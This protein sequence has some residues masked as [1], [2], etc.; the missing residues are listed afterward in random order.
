[1]AL[2]IE[3][4]DAPSKTFNHWLLWNLSPQTQEIKE[5]SVPKDAVLG[6][7]DFGKLIY[8]G[9]CPPSGTHRYVF[10]I[11]ALDNK[12][13]LAQNANRAELDEAMKNHILDIGELAG[14]YSKQ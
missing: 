2:I 13:D 3:D 11:Y 4:P 12:L 10:R 1:M 6:T 9:P 8:G 7:N 5:N 14:L